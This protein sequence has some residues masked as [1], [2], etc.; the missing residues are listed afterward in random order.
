LKLKNGFAEL[1]MCLPPGMCQSLCNFFNEEL[2]TPDS[3]HTVVNGNRALLI[4]HPSTNKDERMLNFIA[5]VKHMMTERFP[6]QFPDVASVRITEIQ[7]LLNRKLFD[8]D[9]DKHV[10]SLMN[11]LVATFMLQTGYTDDQKGT[12][13]LMSPSKYED[14]YDLSPELLK[15]HDITLEEW[16]KMLVDT[17]RRLK[18]GLSHEGV[19][20]CRYYRGKA[21][22]V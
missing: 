19:S 15:K 3:R 7:F 5:L 13:T 12:L 11:N 9:Q 16:Q 18:D 22:Y 2:G 4:V 6:T 8:W 17:I 20:K 21:A 14:F 1:G 10:D